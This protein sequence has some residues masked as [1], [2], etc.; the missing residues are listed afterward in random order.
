MFQSKGGI[1]VSVAG[2]LSILRVNRQLHDEYSE[3]L[4]VT[5]VRIV[6][7]IFAGT[8]LQQKLSALTSRWAPSIK[9][10]VVYHFARSVDENMIWWRERCTVFTLQNLIA[11]LPVLEEVT[12][13]EF[14]LPYSPTLT[15]FENC[16]LDFG[17]RVGM[18]LVNRN[19]MFIG[20]E[21]GQTNINISAKF[22]R[23]PTIVNTSVV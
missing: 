22:N 6:T 7:S 14:Y 12:F 17:H 3:V 18:V 8:D 13:A 23:Y 16:I 15:P 11:T 20:A 2:S 9:A 10:L 1:R 4:G 21:E 19:R 5:N